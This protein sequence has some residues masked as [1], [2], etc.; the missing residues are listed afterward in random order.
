M[1]ETT[2]E[3]YY[4][5]VLSQFL[6][7]SRLHQRVLACLRTAFPQGWITAGA[8]RNSVWDMLSGIKEPPL[9][10]DLDVIYFDPHDTRQKTER[11]I[12]I[13]L[14]QQ[15]PDESQAHAPLQ[16][17]QTIRI[18]DTTGQEELEDALAVTRFFRRREN[19]AGTRIFLTAAGNMND[20]GF[21]YNYPKGL[22]KDK[23]YGSLPPP[24]IRNFLSDPSLGWPVNHHCIHCPLL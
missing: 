17:P 1:T 14:Q 5:E 4:R 21:C 23:I 16:R 2:K 24:H 9:C 20:T 12:E 3:T 10:N 6:R 15:L 22:I 18:Q 8:I 11:E 13:R 19:R 7:E